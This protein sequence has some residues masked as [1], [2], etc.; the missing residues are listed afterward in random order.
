MASLL[1]IDDDRQVLDSMAQWLRSLGHD[2]DA[3]TDQGA[4]TQRLA[5]KRY[6]LVLCDIRLG[7]QDGFDVLSHCREK[8]PQTSVILFTGYGSVETAIEALR[9]GPFDLLTK[10]L[11]DQEL[12]MA[13]DRALAQRKVVEE[14]KELKA[15]LDVRYGI[16]SIVGFDP[17]MQRVFEI[18]ESVADTRA[19]VLVT[20]ESG[21]G[22]SLIARAI[23]RRSSRRDQSFV[24]VA[25]GALP[26]TLLESELF[27]HV[28]GAFTGATGDRL[29]KFKL[30]DGGTL[31]LDEI[32]T[33]SPGMQVKL[34]RVL[35]DL[36][37]EPVGGT[38]TY[39]VDTRTILATN[40]N[41]SEAVADGR[42]REDLFYRIN[43]INLEIPPLRERLADIPVLARHFL[44]LF[45]EESSKP[46]AEFS[47]DAMQILQTYR[48]PGNVR[49]LQNVVAR[50]VLL[51]RSS[52]IQPSDLPPTLTQRPV[53]VGTSASNDGRNLKDALANPE[54]QI[55]MQ[56]LEANGWNRNATA[57]A[58]GINRTTLYKKMKK[59]GIDDRIR[60]RSA[61]IMP[62]LTPAAGVEG[63]P[64]RS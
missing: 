51:G 55:I 3:V 62:P 28:K 1:L 12:L 38:K 30:A 56:M 44:K 39:R 49:E 46:A 43:V 14:N 63:S 58:L 23:H 40:E 21:T 53:M 54:R 31:F 25:C 34:L 45:C 42:F 10:P 6:E 29:G 26:E 33:A 50:S 27:G 60:S 4:A 2:I 35:Q 22:K 7:D 15:R 5:A 11:I 48:W 20:G 61:P 57:D 17:R 37:F 59:L 36:E 64:I 18:I 13:I 52:L 16:D 8:Y 9:A 47:P 32:S 24:E 41:L 19:T